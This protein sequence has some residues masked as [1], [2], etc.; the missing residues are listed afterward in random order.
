MLLQGLILFITFSLLT[1]KCKKLDLQTMFFSC[2]FL[3]IFI[4]IIS[5]F[6]FRKIT[7]QKFSAKVLKEI[8][9]CNLLTF[10]KI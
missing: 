2:F 8:I 3:Y 7:T 4:K 10:L 5:Y 6:Q 9:N 1:V